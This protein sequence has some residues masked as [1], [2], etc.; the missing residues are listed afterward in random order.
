MNKSGY[1]RILCSLTAS[2]FLFSSCSDALSLIKDD[3]QDTYSITHDG[4]GSESGT[5]PKAIH[6]I[7]GAK[8]VISGNIGRLAKK[9]FAFAGWNT[10]KDGLGI[11]F[12]HDVLTTMPRLNLILYALWTPAVYT[13]AWN[14]QDADQPAMPAETCIAESGSSA[15]G[16]PQAP[17]KAGYSFDGWWTEPQGK[18]SRFDADTPVFS[19]ITVYAKWTKNEHFTIYFDAQGGSEV[20]DERIEKGSKPVVNSIPVKEGY[21]FTG[22]YTGTNGSGDEITGETLVTSSITAYA[23][24]LKNEFPDSWRNGNNVTLYSYTGTD[25]HVTIPAKINGYPVTTIG[26]EIFKDNIFLES[27]TLPDSLTR[28]GAYAFSGCIN[29]S[30]IEIPDSTTE[31]KNSTFSGCISLESIQIPESVV[32]IG[33]KAFENCV[34]LKEARLPESLQNLGIASFIN[35]SSLTSTTIPKSIVMI[36]RETFSGCRNLKSI[37]FPE[38]LK[39]IGRNALSNCVK[40]ESIDLPASLE[41]IGPGAFVNCAGLADIALPESLKHIGS[42]AFDSC[43]QLASITIPS[44]ITCIDSGTFI[45][46]TSLSS[47]TMPGSIVSINEKAFDNCRSIESMIIPDSVVSIGSYAFNDCL[48]LKSLVISA[49][50][51]KL[52]SQFIRN[53]PLLETLTLRNPD[54]SSFEAGFFDAADVDS[55]KVPQESLS[56]YKDDP[57]WSSLRIEPISQDSM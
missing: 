24:W 25:A 4:N 37:Q 44:R 36:R 27:I 56:A 43:I 46:C 23:C 33:D 45:N 7:P 14:S 9:G 39:S 41:Y 32:V 35:C 12:Q 53:T 22:W 20:P 34:S 28:I 13:I 42:Y 30:Y 6:E 5:V 16:L 15:D 51:Q 38:T 19:D 3:E 48:N 52:E 17:E 57:S 21:L 11:D 10:Q 47:V 50:I 29:L 18:G 8:I 55:I 26:K 1:I 31:I 54:P 49:S 2:L 40:L